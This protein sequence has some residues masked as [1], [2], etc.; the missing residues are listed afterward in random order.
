MTYR[1]HIQ[2]VVVLCGTYGKL[3]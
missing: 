3:S 1:N 2:T